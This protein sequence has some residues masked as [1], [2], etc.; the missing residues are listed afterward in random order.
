MSTLLLIEQDQE[1]ASRLAKW[2]TLELYEVESAFEGNQALELLQRTKYDFIILDSRLADFSD[3]AICNYSKSRGGGISVLMLILQSAK[4]IDVEHCG[5]DDYL[6]KPFHVRELSA[7]LR[8]L[9]RGGSPDSGTP[10]GQ[11]KRPPSGA[12]V[13]RK[14]ILPKRDAEIAL[15]LD[16]NDS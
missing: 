2:L 14:P 6:T 10:G 9:G 1:L 11:G 8:A 16:D 5:A 7:R 3:G 13:P 4:R 12:P 15:E